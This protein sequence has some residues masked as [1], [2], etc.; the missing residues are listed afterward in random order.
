MAKTKAEK[1]KVLEKLERALA[2]AASVVFVNFHGLSVANAN[3]MRRGLRKD[4]I[5]YFVAKKTL[6]SRALESRGIEGEPPPLQGEIAL[7]YGA[8][9]LAPAR[10][11]AD[12]AKKYKGSLVIAGGVLGGVFRGQREMQDIAAIPPLETLYAQVA[13]LLQSPIQ[14]LVMALSQIAEKRS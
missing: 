14:G 13:N 9:A 2:G 7:A 12:F 10:N 5:G 3:A 1:Q 11:I 6:L 8:D 4:G